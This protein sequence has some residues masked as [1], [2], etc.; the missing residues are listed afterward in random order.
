MRSVLTVAIGA[1]LCAAAWAAEDNPVELKTETDR[2]NY[3]IGFQIGG[4][5][6]RQGVQLNSEAI[7]KGIQ[8]ALGGSAPQMNPD[9]IHRTLVDLKRRILAEQQ[10]RQR[11]E[12]TRRLEDGKGFL[13]ENARKEG[14]VSLPSGLQ[15]RPVQEGTGKQPGPTDT[16]TVHYKGTLI[17]GT[18]FDSSYKTGKPVSFQLNGVIAGWTE[19]LQLMKEGGKAQL[20]IPPQLGY[21]DRGPLAQQTLVFDVEL[22]SVGAKDDAQGSGGQTQPKD[23]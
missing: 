1:G 16:V 23:P 18:E 4:D 9:E 6:K 13:A 11:A 14:V 7:V 8:D 2:I 10:D 19:G 20:F 5:L 12:L 21:G 3:S 22:V 15:Y 17:D